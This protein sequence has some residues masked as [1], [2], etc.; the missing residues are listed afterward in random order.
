LRADEA[1]RTTCVYAHKGSV[2]A[3]NGAKRAIDSRPGIFW[4]EVQA[5][6]GA[7]VQEALVDDPECDYLIPTLAVDSDGNVGL[8]CTRTSEQEFPSAV[9]MMRAAGDPRNTMR[10]PV[11]AA[12]GTTVFASSRKGPYGIQW[13]NYNATCLDPSDPTRIWTCQEYAAGAEV[14]RWTTCWVAFALK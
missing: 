6:D 10:P 8:G 11:L 9:V 13:G 14:D 12:R 3:C 1:R 5:S 7:L 4:C 2:F